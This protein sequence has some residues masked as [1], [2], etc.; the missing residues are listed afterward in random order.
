MKKQISTLLAVAL[1][2]NLAL[3]APPVQ[4]QTGT[5]SFSMN[6]IVG[7]DVFTDTGGMS[8]GRIH[9]FLDTQSGVLTT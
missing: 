3:F 2:A 1:M 6:R 5:V 8:F 4:A 7:D 9:H